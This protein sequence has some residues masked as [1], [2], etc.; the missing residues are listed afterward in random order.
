MSI[1]VIFQV[2]L[3]ALKFPAEMTAFIKLLSKTPD[4]K[5]AEITAALEKQLQ[6]FL[7]TGRPS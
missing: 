4:E 1:A 3:A 6:D 5:K 2:V 7:D